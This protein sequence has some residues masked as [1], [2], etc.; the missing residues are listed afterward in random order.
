MLTTIVESFSFNSDICASYN[1]TCIHN[2]LF[3]LVP[4]YFDWA[5]YYFDWAP[6]YFDWVPYYFDCYNNIYRP[7]GL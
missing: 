3:L 7:V 6:Y 2:H 1:E 5:P 4:Y